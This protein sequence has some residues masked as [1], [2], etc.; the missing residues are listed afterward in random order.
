MSLICRAGSSRIQRRVLQ[1]NTNGAMGLAN[2]VRSN[3][4]NYDVLVVTAANTARLDVLGPR[5]TLKM[6]VD[7]AGQI[8]MT[9]VLVAS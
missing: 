2:V 1:V 8:K 7:G 4:G 6:L 9:K 5:G 3:L